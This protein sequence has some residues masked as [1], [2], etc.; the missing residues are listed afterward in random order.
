MAQFTSIR[1]GPAGSHESSGKR[2]GERFR[3]K[4]RL[5]QH[6]LV[7]RRIIQ[8]IINL[9]GF[10]ASDMVLEIGPGRGSLTLPLARRVCHIVAVE[11]DSN[12]TLSLEKHLH[13]SGITNVT[14]INQDILKWDFREMDSGPSSKIHVIGNLPYN[15]SSPFLEKLIGNRQRVARAVLMFQLEVGR[16]ITACPGGK[17]YGAMSL[18][19]QYH[20]DPTVLIEVP[21]EAFYP[22]PKVDSM[23]VDLDFERPYPRDTTIHEHSFRQ[24]VKGAFAHRRK[25]LINSLSG[26]PSLLFNRDVLLNAMK[27]CEI[28]PKRRAETLDMK[29]FLCLTKV[30]SLTNQQ[31]NDT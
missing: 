4:K 9:S 22:R 11:K 1:A 19:V 3:P 25:T 8:K 16:R 6:F 18:L 23:V 5:G 28:D 7:D 10:Q 20:A 30:L 21:K 13:R 12:L 24:V 27:H 14:L 31:G 26:A 15:I 29:E 17:A 2:G